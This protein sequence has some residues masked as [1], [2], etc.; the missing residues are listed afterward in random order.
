MSHQLCIAHVRNY[1]SR[2]ARSILEQAERE[3]DEKDGKLAELAEDLKVLKE[4]LEE[5]PEEGGRRVRRLHRKYLWAAPPRRKGHEAKEA[6]ASY[7]MS[8]LT[9]EI[10]NK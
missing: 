5:M 10:W 9:L 2:R 1:V 8:L 7:R 3:Y 4:V 6:T